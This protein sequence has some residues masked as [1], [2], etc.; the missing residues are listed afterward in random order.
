[1]VRSG[2][3]T[4]VE[5]ASRVSKSI[6][7]LTESGSALSENGTGQGEAATGLVNLLKNCLPLGIGVNIDGEDGSEDL[8]VKQLVVGRRRLVNGRLDVETNRVVVLATGNQ[9]KL[10]ILVALVDD[11]LDLIE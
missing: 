8:L 7:S 11:G 9:L 5:V 6:F 10:G 3:L 4:K 1:M 2:T